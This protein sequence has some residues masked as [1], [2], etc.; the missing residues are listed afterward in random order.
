MG[1]AGFSQAQQSCLPSSPRRQHGQQGPQGSLSRASHSQAAG[2]LREG[3]CLP[4]LGPC[5]ALDYLISSCHGCCYTEIQSLFAQRKLHPRDIFE[6]IAESPPWVP[7]PDISAT[8]LT[9]KAPEPQNLLPVPEL[10]VSLLHSSSLVSG[11]GWRGG[12]TSCD[13]RVCRII[14]AAPCSLCKP[15]KG[16]IEQGLSSGML[17]P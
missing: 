13:P 11:L 8:L 17:G 6:E 10:S 9:P 3:R 16:P 2:M 15:P 1:A 4:L 7:T 5:S 14:T 12:W